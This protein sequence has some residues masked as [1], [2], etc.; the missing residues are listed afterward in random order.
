MKKIVTLLLL[1]VC[2]GAAAQRPYPAEELFLKHTDRLYEEGRKWA[3]GGFPMQADWYYAQAAVAVESFQY[4]LISL[5]RYRLEQTEQA[6]EEARYKAVMSQKI[7]V[8]DSVTDEQQQRAMELFGIDV[9]SMLKDLQFLEDFSDE[10][11]AMS[12]SLDALT[13][14]LQDEISRFGEMM[15][16]PVEWDTWRAERALTWD[17]I[18]S[19]SIVSPWPWFFEAV[20]DLLVGIPAEEAAE[21]YGYALINPNM[22]QDELDFSFLETITRDEIKALYYRLD[23]RRA[24]YESN[25]GSSVQTSLVRDY[26]NFSFEHLVQQGITLLQKDEAA[27]ASAAPWFVAAVKA[28][29]F[30]ADLLCLA[31]SALIANRDIEAAAS[32]INMGM[33]LDP[34]NG[35]LQS[36]VSELKQDLL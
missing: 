2:L 7:E 15:G 24:K 19:Q 6:Q 21:A 29:P 17:R 26:R 13:P 25:L 5:S 20:T 12:D 27:Y 10:V 32:Y 33:L 36:L 18:A 34:T 4:A 1:C 11:D 23:A 16:T 30:D 31:A 8:A 3:S 14:V 22:P 9:N 35:N 28:F